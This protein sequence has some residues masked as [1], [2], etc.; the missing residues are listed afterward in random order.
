MKSS[1]ATFKLKRKEPSSLESQYKRNLRS[2][3]TLP[4]V[5]GTNSE[6]F[7][8]LVKL[9]ED[10]I[11]P[12]KIPESVK[13]STA[14]KSAQTEGKWTNLFNMADM[15]WYP[16]ED[17]EDMSDYASVRETHDGL[18]PSAPPEVSTSGTSSSDGTASEDS[19]A[20]EITDEH[21]VKRHVVQIH[22]QKEESDTSSSIEVIK[23]HR[24]L[25]SPT[26]EEQSAAVYGEEHPDSMTTDWPEGEGMNPPGYDVI[27]PPTK[28]SKGK[29]GSDIKPEKLFPSISGILDQVTRSCKSVERYL[30]KNSDHTEL[31]RDENFKH[32]LTLIFTL[33]IDMT[34]Y[35]R[36]GEFADFE[37]VDDTVSETQAINVAGH[38]TPEKEEDHSVIK[39]DLSF[40]QVHETTQHIDQPQ[41]DRDIVDNQE[42]ELDYHKTVQERLKLLNNLTQTLEGFH[43]EN[44]QTISQIVDRV[45]ELEGALEQAQTYIQTNIDQPAISEYRSP[46]PEPLK[47]VMAVKTQKANTYTHSKH[48]RDEGVKEFRLGIKQPPIA[49]RQKLGIP[50]PGQPAP[51]AQPM[52]LRGRQVPA[53]VA[54]P[55]PPLNAAQRANADPALLQILNSVVDMMRNPVEKEDPATKFL[56]FPKTVF[57]GTDPAQARSHWTAF[58]KFVAYQNDQLQNLGN[59]DEIKKYFANT[60]A[61]QAYL[62]FSTVSPNMLNIENIKDKF[63]KRYNVWGQT[64]KQHVTAWNRL[65]FD[66]N[67]QEVEEYAADVKMLGTMLANTQEQIL[68]KF[69]ESFPS[70]IEAQLL[71][72]DTLNEAIKKAKDLIQVFKSDIPMPAASSVLIH[73]AVEPKKGKSKKKK[74]KGSNQEQNLDQAV[75]NHEQ[76]YTGDSTST[77][78]SG[79]VRTDDSKRGNKQNQRGQRGKGRKQNNQQQGSGRGF[80]PNA[81]EFQ[82]AAQQSQ[83]EVVYDQNSQYAGAT[84]QDQQAEYQQ[85]SWSGYNNQQNPPQ[86]QNYN[87]QSRGRGFFPRRPSR[88][89]RGNYRGRGRGFNYSQNNQSQWGNYNQQYPQTQYQQQPNAQASGYQGQQQQGPSYAMQ[90]QNYTCEICTNKGHYAHECH[91]AFDQLNFLAEV[92]GA[93]G[94]DPGLCATSGGQEPA[95]L[96]Y[97]EDQQQETE[98]ADFA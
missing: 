18:I 29:H 51:P 82:P 96:S 97:H 83:T 41:D 35:P 26:G 5:Q 10:T 22:A 7:A 57:N 87:S 55:P 30:R 23:P 62:W 50:P 24:S 65:Q 80:N 37:H 70:Q 98:Q 47:N 3:G 79:F 13:Q 45:S 90:R 54:V 86:Y 95:N 15:P 43:H 84:G 78:A 67:K 31:L 88:G 16:E 21:K 91:Q 52:N 74:N 81:Q 46:S 14:Q 1:K 8:Q 53:V 28:M 48:P 42:K 49:P 77:P 76:S 9:A 33:E 92:I 40:E 32:L 4:Q 73:S 58:E 38:Q 60:L 2:Q 72:I 93:S 6:Q 20:D 68:E 34:A 64:H 39:N 11:V 17:I 69:K 75:N 94:I 61:D 25:Y 63:L 27:N 59:I 89:Y 44:K 12:P 19:E 66:H 71:D 85:Q 36:L 56:M